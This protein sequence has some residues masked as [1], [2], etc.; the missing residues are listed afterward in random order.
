M[1]PA[2]LSFLAACVSLVTRTIIHRPRCSHASGRAVL[3]RRFQRALH[4]HET[5]VQGCSTQ[6]GPQGQATPVSR[7]PA[8]LL[9]LPAALQQRSS[10]QRQRQAV[11]PGL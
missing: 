2:V 6:A 9:S 3:T 5:A 10:S 4:E 8:T 7:F 11:T 1:Q